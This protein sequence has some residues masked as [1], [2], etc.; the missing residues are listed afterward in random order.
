MQNTTWQNLIP[1]G[2]AQEDFGF[3]GFYVRN[4][5]D[6]SLQLIALNTNLY[7]RTNITTADPCSQL[8]WLENK[9]DEARNSNKKVIVSGHVPPGFYER[10]Y[11]G[12]FF[13]NGAGS[14]ANDLFVNLVNKYSDVVSNYIFL[15]CAAL[16]GSLYSCTFLL[17]SPI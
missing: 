3:C 7:Y 10:N 8:I 4:F 11:I 2:Q 5:K 17:L 9:L 6:T 16:E 1:E 14:V 15:G 13:T 12:P